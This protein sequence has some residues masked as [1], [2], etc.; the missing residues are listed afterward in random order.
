MTSLSTANATSIAKARFS[1]RLNRARTNCCISISY[2]DFATLLLS[3]Q[4]KLPNGLRSR[5]AL[6]VSVPSTQCDFHF[7]T[8]QN[9][10]LDTFATCSICILDRNEGVLER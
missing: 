4:D 6:K 10:L 7:A 9:P 8:S 1:L 5:S 3:P 2:S